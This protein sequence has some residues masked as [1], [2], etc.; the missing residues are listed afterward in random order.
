MN[1]VGFVNFWPD[2][3]VENPVLLL[4]RVTIGTRRV[5]AAP[6]QESS[7]SLSAVR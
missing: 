3:S 4:N 7:I 5:A 6:S 2:R 1:L